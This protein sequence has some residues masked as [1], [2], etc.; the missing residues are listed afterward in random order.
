M[1]VCGSFNAWKQ[2]FEV[3]LF[4]EILDDFWGTPLA[5]RERKDEVPS[6]NGGPG[7]VQLEKVNRDPKIPKIDKKSSSN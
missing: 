6:T 1:T 3:V 7:G 4:S 2:G 5:I